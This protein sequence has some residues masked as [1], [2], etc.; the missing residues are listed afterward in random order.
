MNKL[1]STSEIIELLNKASEQKDIQCDIL[2]L[3]ICSVLDEVD[4]RLFSKAVT[5]TIADI[6]KEIV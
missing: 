1:K 6:K 5:E 4:E 3:Y 2:E